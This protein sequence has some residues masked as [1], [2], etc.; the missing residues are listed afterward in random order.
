M[1]NLNPSS[2][3]KGN[4]AMGYIIAGKLLMGFLFFFLGCEM[5]K[6]GTAYKFIFCRLIS[7]LRKLLFLTL[8]LCEFN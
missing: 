2:L 7:N 1:M 5:L 8:V 3:H 6:N 4:K